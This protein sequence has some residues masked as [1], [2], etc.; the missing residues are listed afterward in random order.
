MR[1]SPEN[2]PPRDEYLT[3]ILYPQQSELDADVA[4]DT[5]EE[6]GGSDLGEGS[7][8]DEVRIGRAWL[9]SSMGLSFLA[10]AD[11][12]IEF[13][14]LVK[15]GT[16]TYSEDDDSS[17]WTRSSLESSPVPVSW[18]NGEIDY[19]KDL[20]VFGIPG[21][22]LFIRSAPADGFAQFTVCII[23]SNE[24]DGTLDFQARNERC[25]YQTRL[26][27]K[28]RDGT[29][30]VPR[31]SHYV[32]TEKDS[33]LNG[34]LYRNTHEYATGHTCSATWDNDDDVPKWIATSWM[35]QQQVD[36]VDPGGDP[37]LQK[38][39]QEIGFEGFAAEALS[40]LPDAELLQLL[41]VL[42]KVYSVWL[43][44]EEG[45]KLSSLNE[46]LKEV[47]AGQLAEARSV[48]ERM[49]RSIDTL[50]NN[51][52]A[53]TAFRL[54]NRAMNRQ[55]QWQGN[56]LVW[57]PFQLGFALLTLSSMV[58][59]NQDR[60]IMDLLWFPTG[61]GKTEAYL[62]LMAFVLFY[63][64]LEKGSLREE[65]G[66]AVITRYTLRAL[67]TDQ[68]E[69]TVAMICACELVRREEDPQARNSKPFSLG[70]WIGSGSTPNNYE[71]AKESLNG[72][73]GATPRVIESCP[74]CRSV[75]EW[76]ANDSRKE[77]RVRCPSADCEI[78]TAFGWLPI[79]TVDEQIYHHHP[80]I[81]IGT[82]DKFAQVCR[83]PTRTNGL[84]NRGKSYLP[85]DLI[86][87][88]ELHLISGPLGTTTGLMELA[89][90]WLCS[91]ED[92]K[93][94]IIGS[95]ATI[96]RANEQVGALFDRAVCQ[97]P[98]PV[99]DADNSF[100]A[101]KKVGSTGRIYMGITTAGRTPT[102]MLQAICGSLLQSIDDADFADHSDALDP[103][104]TLATYFNSL[105]ILGGARTLLWEDAQ[106]S[107]GVFAAIREEEPRDV[108]DLQE[109]TS[110]VSQEELKQT[111]ARLKLSRGDEGHVDM[112]LA[113]V[114]LSVGVNIP[115][116]G[117]MVVGRP[118]KDDG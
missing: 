39:L 26:E 87:Q 57:R 11:S 44:G 47:A 97:F 45:E 28:S 50:R 42:P 88:D 65:D 68:F 114:M 112:L 105:R 63:R 15:T 13:E 66:V 67:T 10:S 117:L 2:R 95:T 16:Y 38:A 101:R 23:N 80:S 53:M 115:R 111:L 98:T 70:L 96:Q 91:G 33:L 71:K 90:D 24:D 118:A 3:G 99:I 20:E 79:H 78:G 76:E 116:L 31:R 89:I 54:A 29:S 40:E 102:F 72:S 55:M 1:C 94:K 93:P 49:N 5:S 22:R 106:K 86:V 59:R 41:E 113:S 37:D 36:D 51:A 18:Q 92:H 81:I 58:D 7:L 74:V 17:S 104:T 61:G 8:A 46:D 60:D 73:F 103:Y 6:G 52:T 14:L 85:P 9:P 108:E 32:G 56:D 21:M 35:P 48:I 83:F 25:F 12:R 27:I 34:L 77:I 84:F 19:P 110:A 4:E 109:L 75:F 43:D 69:R 82:V 62:L 64:R 100:F 30:F 107:K